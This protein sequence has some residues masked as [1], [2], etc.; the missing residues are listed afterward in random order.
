MIFYL[1]RVWRASDTQWRN[2]IT[3]F[4]LHT[5]RSNI[6][7]YIFG[8][9]FICPRLGPEEHEFG[10]FGF[11]APNVTE[12]FLQC[13]QGHVL[14]EIVPAKEF[15]QWHDDD[16]SVLAKSATRQTT[17]TTR[18]VGKRREARGESEGDDE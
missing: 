16:V 17:A 18:L 10:R 9:A 14:G 15:D 3:F 1:T 5:V 4:I 6:D 7:I 2:Y 8:K 12:R 13:R 11:G